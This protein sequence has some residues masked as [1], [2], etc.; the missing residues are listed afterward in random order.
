MFASTVA[1]QE[2]QSLKAY[3]F[4]VAYRLTGSASDAEDMVQDAWMRYLDAGAPA[5]D[6]LR[7]YLSTIVSRLSLDYLRSARVR[8][9]HYVGSWLP[10][11]VLTSSLQPG[12]EHAVEIHEDLSMAMLIVLDHLTPEQRVVYVLRESYDVPFQ[13]IAALLGKDVAACRQILRRARVRLADL[14]QPSSASTPAPAHLVSALVQALSSGDVPSLA[15]LL[16]ENV[17]WTS[18]AGSEQRAARRPIRGVDRVSRGIAGIMSKFVL[19]Q[20]GRIAVANLNGN[21]AVIIYDGSE[22]STVLQFDADASGIANVWFSR[23]P[24]KL[25]HVGRGLAAAA[26][27]A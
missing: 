7:A 19:A 26:C 16:R 3:L 23:N 2:Y 15:A 11:P 18:D 4:T 12:P 5:V 25:A 14:P 21:S 27:G 6:S 17:T 13:E 8:R 20:D 24:Q 22:V 1:T 9:E 10:E